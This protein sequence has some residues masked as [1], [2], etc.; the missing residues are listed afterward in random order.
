HQASLI[1]HAD[2]NAQA[3]T[4]YSGTQTI[5]ADSYN[6]AYRL[7][8]NARNIETYNATGLFPTNN[9]NNV[10][11][12]DTLIDYYNATTT[13]DEVSFLDNIQLSVADSQFM[14]GLGANAALLAV[15]GLGDINDLDNLSPLST[16]LLYATTLP[17]NSS[18]L[19][20]SL[21]DT[22]GV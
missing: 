17:V 9:P 4:L 2:V 11:P 10:N 22:T 8:D 19:Y 14:S 21:P 13:W 18:G 6:G 5:T 20:V 15:V 3:K 7:R 16:N 12:F 1:A